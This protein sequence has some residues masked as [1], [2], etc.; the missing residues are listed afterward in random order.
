MVSSWV[1]SVP[2]DASQAARGWLFPDIESGNATQLDA[3]PAGG[4][5]QLDA[6]RPLDDWIRPIGDSGLK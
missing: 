6:L 4:S 3:G 2:D 5:P 1:T